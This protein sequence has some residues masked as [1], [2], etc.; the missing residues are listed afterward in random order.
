MFYLNSREVGYDGIKKL[1]GAKV[2]TSAVLAVTSDCGRSMTVAITGGL[3]PQHQDVLLQV[4]AQAAS[5]TFIRRFLNQLLLTQGLV[6]SLF[7]LK[8]DECGLN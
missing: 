8:R 3:S 1:K 5:P 2:L 7:V 6:T 4:H